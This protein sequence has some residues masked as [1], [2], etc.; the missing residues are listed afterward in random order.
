VPG[1]H[2]FFTWPCL[3]QTS[4]RSG[5]LEDLE[6]LKDRLGGAGSAIFKDLSVLAQEVR[7]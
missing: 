7:P 2:G 3:D 4:V 5:R 6:D 1:K